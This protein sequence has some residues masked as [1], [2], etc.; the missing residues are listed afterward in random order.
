MSS[1][2]YCDETAIVPHRAEGYEQ[3]DGQ[4]VNDE[5]LSMN[6]PG[7]AG[8]LCSTV[9]DMLRWQRALDNNTLITA[10][11]RA[12]MVTEATLN[13]GSPTGYAY[14][15]FVSD[16][17]GHRKVWHAG[18]INGFNT[19]H[20]TYPDDDLVVTAFINTNGADPMALEAQITR[21]LMGIPL[22]E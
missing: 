14:G 7:A 11:S 19:M 3:Q 15:L 9:L 13:D 18:G 22:K 5:A 17:E 21:L 12:M 20:A 1:S 16:F 4:L 8:A 6:T 10:E 2:S